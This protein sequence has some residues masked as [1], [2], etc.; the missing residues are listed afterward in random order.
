[1]H[2]HAVVTGHKWNMEQRYGTTPEHPRDS[3]VH[4]CKGFDPR[5][6]LRPTRKKGVRVVAGTY[7]VHI[8]VVAVVE[9]ITAQNWYTG[10]F[11]PPTYIL[12]VST[13]S[14]ANTRL[15]LILVSVSLA[16]ACRSLTLI[17]VYTKSSDTR[18]LHCWEPNR[19]CGIDWW[20]WIRTRRRG[21][22]LVVVIVVTP[23][24]WCFVP[25]FTN[26]T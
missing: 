7:V 6:K 4:E 26:D 5:N 1:M 20:R 24:I 2:C 11:L 8:V 25:L 18:T 21:G 3:H 15:L 14:D 19:A 22:I 9:V 17:D 10:P 16:V 12:L 13:R 23:P